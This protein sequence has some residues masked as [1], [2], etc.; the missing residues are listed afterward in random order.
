MQY[1]ARWDSLL[2]LAVHIPR[3]AGSQAPRGMVPDHISHVHPIR[4]VLAIIK[5]PTP[6]KFIYIRETCNHANS[7]VTERA[8]ALWSVCSAQTNKTKKKNFPPLAGRSDPVVRHAFGRGKDRQADFLGRHARDG[9]VGPPS[10]TCG[11]GPRA[12]PHWL[13]QGAAMRCGQ[14]D[15]W[16]LAPPGGQPP[17]PK[18]KEY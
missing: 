11:D 10:R 4:P 2:S 1:Y 5:R 14:K 12:W 17:P 3:I 18:K 7:V 6:T 13:P 16:P 15:E 8:R 9:D